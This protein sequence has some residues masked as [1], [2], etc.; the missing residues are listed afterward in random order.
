MHE[1]VSEMEHGCGFVGVG[2][3]GEVV[4]LDW[5]GVPWWR[6]GRWV[7]SENAPGKGPVR[8]PGQRKQ[9]IAVVLPHGRVDTNIRK[10]VA[11]RNLE[12][13]LRP[14]AHS[15]SLQSVLLA[16]SPALPPCLPLIQFGLDSSLD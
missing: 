13:A 9:G 7:I 11:M 8:L 1:G 16:R 15:T 5:V 2:G 12:S 3:K 6:G 14:G 4:I 10:E